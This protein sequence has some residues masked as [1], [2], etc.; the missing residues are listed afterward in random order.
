MLDRRKG[1]VPDCVKGG[2]IGGYLLSMVI[3]GFSA[4]ALV[5]GR[6]FNRSLETGLRF[7]HHRKHS[8]IDFDSYIDNVGIVTGINNLLPYNNT[9]MEWGD[10][11]LFDAYVNW[12][13]NDHFSAELTGTNLG[14]IYYIDPITRSA[15]PAPGRTLKLAFVYQF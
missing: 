10:I 7:T 3:P 9:P 11:T 2:F 13:F 12:R 14:N 8:N 5:G 6:F 1:T 15:Y 4:N